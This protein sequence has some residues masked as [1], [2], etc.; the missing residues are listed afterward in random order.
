MSP[1]APEPRRH[2]WSARPV[3]SVE[4]ESVEPGGPQTTPLAALSDNETLIVRGRL[5]TLS[6]APTT[7]GDGVMVSAQWRP[8]GEWLQLFVLPPNGT[9]DRPNADGLITASDDAIDAN[10]NFFF[11]TRTHPW[12]RHYDHDADD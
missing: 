7:D 11:G 5:V 4:V 10:L 12:H 6:I 2:D 8:D 3:I 9:V 1:I